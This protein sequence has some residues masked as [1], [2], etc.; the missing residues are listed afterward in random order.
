MIALKGSP[1]GFGTDL[2]GSSRIPAAFNGLYALKTTEGRLSQSGLATVLRG[3]PIAA[4]SLGILSQSIDGLAISFKAI[5]ESKPWLYDPEVA[6]IPWR[7]DKFNSI[8][9]R[10]CS[11]GLQN[12]RLTF[13][14]LSS[15]DFVEP[16]PTI[17]QAIAI[18]KK[19][20]Q[21][22]G[23]EV[24][25]WKPPKQNTA[26][27]NLFRIFGA[28]SGKCIREAIDAS[29]EPPV[30]QLKDWYSQEASMLRIGGIWVVL[31]ALVGKSMA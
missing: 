8:I 4:G 20:L 23:Y 15:D 5:L 30:E 27:D 22:C 10:T 3:L 12:G 17:G 18:V 9:S 14:I 31:P 29:G 24:V 21:H 2:A 7:Q 16:H 11:P 28:D 13:G 1:L 6:E 26:V 25:D 19:A